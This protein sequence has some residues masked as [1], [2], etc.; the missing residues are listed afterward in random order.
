MIVRVRPFSSFFTFTRRYCST[1]IAGSLDHIKD[2]LNKA[3][4][5]PEY[6][7]AFTSQITPTKPSG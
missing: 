7:A 2:S 4:N 5:L 1:F 6:Q 3:Y